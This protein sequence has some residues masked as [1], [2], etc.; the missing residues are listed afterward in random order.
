M[1]DR[2]LGLLPRR[3]HRRALIGVAA[4]A[5]GGM[6]LWALQKASAG[7]SF[8]AMVVALRATS[9]TALL[10]SLAATSLSFLALLGYDFSGLRYAGAR[11][12]WPAVLLA[13][14]CGFAIGNTVGLGAFSG[15]AVRYRL[16]SAVG[17]SPGQIARVIFFIATAFG[18]GLATIA[19]LG[20]VLRADEVSGLLGGRPEP[21]RSAAAVILTLATAFLIFCAVRRTSL[22]FGPI[23]LTPPGGRIV[24]IQ[25]GLAA[26]DILAAATALWVLLPASGTSFIAFAAVYAAALTLGVLSHV[27]GGL[28]VFEVAILCAFGNKAPPSA[29]AAALVIYRAIYFLLPM[30]LA[31]VLLAGFEARRA[32]YSEIGQRFG[33]A[34]AQLAPSFIS[35]TTFG[36]GATLVVS[37]AMPA[38]IDRLQILQVSVPL[39]AVETSHL[40]S[41]IAG[42]VLLFAARGLFHRLDGAWWLAFSIIL[43]SIPFALT[44]GLAIVAPSV[45]GFLLIGLVMARRQFRRHASLLP[46]PL[47]MGWLI[48]VGC[49]L[50][51]TVWILFFAF[52][53]VEYGHE[54]WWQFEFDAT[55]PRA[56]RA[57]V[58][59]AVL[60]L[61]LGLAQLLRPAA[62]FIAPPTTADLE[63]ARRI[64]VQQPRPEGLLALMGD[65]SFLF[66]DSGKAFLM[67][68]KRGRT[69]AALGD[70]VG[71]PKERPEL[72]WRFVELA[73]AHGGRA[74]FYQIPASSLPLYLDAG[75]KLLKVGE[76]AHVPLAAFSLDGSSRA[77]LRY[78]L[79][80]GSRDGLDFEVIPP[81][82]VDAVIDQ[83][84]DISDVWLAGQAVG[85][86]GFSVA[87]FTRDFVFAQSVALVRQHCRPIAFA[88]VMTTEA[89]QEATVGL[90]R[91]RPGEASRYAMEYLFVRLMEWAR[92]QG[93]RSFSLGVAPL[94][95]F[96]EHRLAPRWHRLGR[97]IWAYGH[98]FYNF[99]GLR[100]FKDKFDP[101]WEPRYLAASG[102]FAP[103]FALLDITA[104]T[105]GGLFRTVRRGAA[106]SERPR[107]HAKAVLFCGATAISILS[108]QPAIAFDSG[109]LGD[110]H[111]VDPQGAMRGL[112]V[113][114]SDQRGWTQISNE[115]AAAAARAG[116][117]VIGVDLPAYLHRLDEHR[118]EGCLTAV[119]DIEWA[120]RQVQR[121]NA[122][123]HTPI[124]AGFAEGGVLAEAVLAQARPSTV[125][126]AVI[127]DPTVSLHTDAPLCS[128]PP[129]K[130]SPEGGFSYG[131]WLS[132][133]GFLTVGLTP[134]AGSR[135]RRYVED[136]KVAGTP[137]EIDKG[138]GE[139]DLP[140]AM[141]TLLNPRLDALL[142]KA[143]G[144]IA[145]L[146]LVELPAVPSG[147]LLAIIFSGDGGWRDID[148]M[149]A[150]KLCSDSVSVIGWDSLRYFWSRKSPEQIA[151]DLGLVIDTY[152]V[153]W[154]ASKVALI[155]Y[156]FGAGILPFAYDRLAREAKERVVQLSL[157]GFAS[158][159]DFEISITGWL[160]APASKDAAP[161]EPA[162]ASID[163][164]MI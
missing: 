59:V 17:L 75:L 141:A 120:S 22:R 4:L 49:V 126:G 115:V 34:A 144:G 91:H 8:D 119:S 93:Y 48:A 20:L 137:L 114:F 58:G 107:V 54:L 38:F 60:G 90:M 127:V 46:H 95:G 57:V 9:T 136:L 83:L 86:K 118:A 89:K 28:G 110:V 130:S 92:D 26:L 55:A 74:V 23:N 117:L 6:V 16:Y 14:F 147:R 133:S 152:T 162:L 53:D 150:Q 25:I 40:L 5:L 82:N 43:L 122:S 135:D 44:K 113:L 129:A 97:L 132:L 88:T 148:K 100:T 125:A 39:W 157:L 108:T 68:A 151:N 67:F 69:W 73:D 116:A 19:A 64:A 149:I 15:G 128:N 12:P 7:V 124:L 102:C 142:G 163:P 158:T 94:S 45:A 2:G 109:N 85:E 3:V 18:I 10:G 24:L 145:S 72:V 52:Y 131:P 143:K 33:R 155:G 65:K 76:E 47:T 111:V 70:P 101:I 61:A 106:R 98:S 21:L 1:P 32:L 140:E 30:L 79:K 159:T 99:Q 77:G 35:V 36:V 31:T 121:G 56:L 62:G 63:R 51:A 29:V 80:R 139:A 123:Y 156:S 112:V 78:A 13:S 96:G 154:G 134:S 105:A 103:Y 104:L 160:G 138:V 146:P 84:E 11:L 81:G 153:R 161:T 87:A 42:L 71:S 164:R 37:G 27:P 50:V 41:S 66:S